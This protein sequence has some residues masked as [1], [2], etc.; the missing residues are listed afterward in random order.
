M[1]CMPLALAAMVLAAGLIGPTLAA[2]SL[3]EFDNAAERQRY[4]ALLEELR[5]L[6]CQN[7]SLESSDAALAQDLRN[8]VYRLVVVEDRPRE[9]A[10]EF[11]TDRYGDFV[12]YRPPVKTTTLLLWAGPAVALAGGLIIVAVVARRRAAAPQLAEDERD[13]ARRLLGD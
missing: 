8:E 5:C 3:R 11:L 2:E 7:Q 13:R 1:R 9:A 6:V 12:L 4:H 10:V